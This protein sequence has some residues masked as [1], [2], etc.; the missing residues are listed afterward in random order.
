MGLSNEE[1]F[2]KFFWAAGHWR[3]ALESLEYKVD[4]DKRPKV[5]NW[6][7]TVDQLVGRTHLRVSGSGGLHW[8]IGENSDNFLSFM[9]DEHS[10]E[11]PQRSIEDVLGAETKYDSA[12]W[13][14]EHVTY[15]RLADH[16]TRHP[17]KAQPGLFAIAAWWDAYGYM[18][19]LHYPMKRY[20]DELFGK[21]VL[22]SFEQ[23]CGEI[24]NERFEVCFGGMSERATL[25]EQYLLAKHKLFHMLLE[26]EDKR[27]W[28]DKAIKGS[29]LVRRVGQMSR[30]QMVEVFKAAREKA[31]ERTKEMN[32]RD[33]PEADGLFGP[34][35]LGEDEAQ[36]NES[37][38]SEQAGEPAAAV[39]GAVG[40]DDGVLPAPAKDD[41]GA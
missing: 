22:A 11:Y 33:A 7:Q 35:E 38:S 36:P 3:D 32:K 15:G 17:F 27:E 5:R 9:L 30:K 31:W 4:E 16:L 10:I 20:D 13:W 41:G 2:T 40:S 28:F 18:T 1:R 24:I 19:A 25:V 26:E 8:L 29:E 37:A 39:G 14:S 34:S 12:A 6:I 21:D 23:L